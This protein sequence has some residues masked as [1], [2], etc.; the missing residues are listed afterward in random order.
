[1]RKI[2]YSHSKKMRKVG[3]R[4]PRFFL[5]KSSVFWPQW[6]NLTWNQKAP[7]NGGFWAPPI[8]LSFE[9]DSF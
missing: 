8:V 5:P 6:I 2:S 1:M 7:R 9:K 4:K 3:M